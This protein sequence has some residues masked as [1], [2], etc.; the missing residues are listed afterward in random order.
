MLIFPDVTLVRVGACLAKVPAGL[1]DPEP[2]EGVSFCFFENFL[3]VVWTG[4]R[5]AACAVSH[6]RPRVSGRGVV[7]VPPSISRGCRLVPRKSW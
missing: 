6:R 3:S 4:R 5:P 1:D 2:P 7:G